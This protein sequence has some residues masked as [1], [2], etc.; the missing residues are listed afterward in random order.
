MVNTINFK[1]YCISPVFDEP[2]KVHAIFSVENIASG[3][4]RYVVDA[5]YNNNVNYTTDPKEIPILYINTGKNIYLRQKYDLNDSNIA[6]I[7]AALYEIN[8]DGIYTLTRSICGEYLYSDYKCTTNQP[9]VD[10]NQFFNLVCC[11]KVCQNED[12]NND[13]S[14]P[15]AMSI[16]GCR[17]C[18]RNI[19][20][21]SMWWI[22]ILFCLASLIFLF[23]VIKKY[24]KDSHFYVSINPSRY[25]KF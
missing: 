4:I 11:E 2:G 18:Q 5:F 10:L 19:R 14:S 7:S 16:G 13:I 15:Y 8:E 25:L 9:T 3:N 1:L 22:L 6:I 17:S 21:N 23:V 12:P 24:K 20:F